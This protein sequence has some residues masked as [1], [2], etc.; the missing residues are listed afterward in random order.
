MNAQIKYVKSC[1]KNIAYRVSG[2]GSKS[3]ILVNGWVTNLEEL[4][5]L[6][7]LE[8]WLRDLQT[9]SSLT[10]FDKRGVGLS[11]RV[12]EQDLPGL[13]ERLEDIRAIM[14]REQIP[15]ATLLGISEGGPI[16]L[17]FAHKYPHL[18]ES[19]IIIGSF[20]R[21]IEDETYP[22]GIS[23]EL[24][25]KT[26]KEIEDNWGKPIGYQLMAPSLQNS[27]IFKKAWASFLRKS[28][29]PGTAKTF[30]HMNLNIDVRKLLPEINCP[31]L[32]MHRKGDR[33]IPF[34]LGRYMANHLPQ[35]SFL[36]L[37]GD[38]HLPWVGDVKP[39]TSA[40]AQFMGEHFM[41]HREVLEEGKLQPEDLETLHALK[42]HLEANYFEHYSIEELCYQFN[43]NAF[44]LKYGFKKLFGIPVM[45][46]VRE[47][48]LK[49]AKKLLEKSRLSVKEVAYKIGYRHPESFSK[50]FSRLYDQ[51]PSEMR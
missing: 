49:H 50:A 2:Q 39:I 17:A 51:S 41:P 25:A 27:E 48:R 7:G 9:F 16:A 31:A 20:A 1:S 44:K 30:Y 5:T 32:I 11:D 6:P 8:S 35:A 21:W 36:P 43:I 28:A 47:A 26:V 3:L 29:S 14:N 45:Q 34:Q 4:H 19:I 24:H 42:T 33:L 46:F 22:H 12:N 13:S 18:V 23:T 38:D 15:K 37:D 40:I 10:V